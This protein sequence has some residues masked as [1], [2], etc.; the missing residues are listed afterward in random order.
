MEETAIRSVK[1]PVEATTL[2]SDLRNFTP[3]LNASRQDKDGVNLFC[4][5]L[6]SF[7]ADCLTSCL[8][9]V[10]PSMRSS[11]PFYVSSTGDGMLVVF[12]GEW[13]FGYGFLAAIVM[14]YAL[15][16]RCHAYNNDPQYADAPGTSYGIGVESG[17][18][19]HVQANPA[20]ALTRHGI[21]TYIGHCINVAARA[22][23][24]S[25]L[26]HQANTIVADTSVELLGRALFGRT[27]QEFRQREALCA[28]DENVLLFTTR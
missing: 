2:I 27:F 20:A 12:L 25:K 10:P 1:R 6:S 4:N 9:A 14:D 8:I 26:L 19:S 21:D 24:I 3:N 22:E 15:N 16:R 13:H 11:A 18:V 23:S 5:F 7:Y 17:Q 28:T